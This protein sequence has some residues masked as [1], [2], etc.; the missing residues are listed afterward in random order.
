MH[1][2]QAI[3]KLSLSLRRLMCSEPHNNDKGTHSLDSQMDKDLFLKKKLKKKKKL[4]EFLRTL[5]SNLLAYMKKIYICKNS[6]DI[7]E[8][9]LF[10]EYISI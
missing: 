8:K 10:V 6:L 1:P 7:I 3:D 4:K 5:S 9:K 2:H